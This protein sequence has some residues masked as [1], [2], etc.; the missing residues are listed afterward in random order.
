M[1]DEIAKEPL[2]EE[3]DEL[4]NEGSYETETRN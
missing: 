3:I 4:I 1:K 2:L